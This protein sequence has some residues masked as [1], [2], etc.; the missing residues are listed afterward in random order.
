[1]FLAIFRLVLSF[2]T[3]EM[4]AIFQVHNQPTQRRP[5]V[6]SVNGALTC[7]NAAFLTSFR[8]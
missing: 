4:S 1:M 2:E 7:K 6:F 5:Q 3:S 8:R